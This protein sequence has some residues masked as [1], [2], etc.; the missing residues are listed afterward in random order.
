VIW[1]AVGTPSLATGCQAV[2]YG[3]VL[4]IVDLRQLCSTLLGPLAAFGVPS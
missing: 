1:R 4:G 2:R 3:N